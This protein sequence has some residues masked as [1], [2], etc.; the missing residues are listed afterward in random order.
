VAFRYAPPGNVD[1][2]A[3]RPARD[4]FLD[5]WH[6]GMLENFQREI[7]GLPSTNRLFFSE[8]TSAATSGDLPITWNAFPLSIA[9]NIPDDR[10][11]RW[12]AAD[13]P[14]SVDRSTTA[15]AVPMPCR[16]QDEYCE[17]FVYRPAPGG[18]ISR[19]VFTA[20][21]PE[22]WIALAKHDFERVLQLYRE[23]VSP[24]VQPDELKLKQDIAFS[25][26]VVLKKGTY[27]PYNRWNST[28]GVMHLTH[29]ANTLGAEI[30]LAARATIPRRDVSGNRVTDVRRFA[31]GSNFGDPNRSSDPNIGHGVNFTALPGAGGVAQSITLADPVALYID[32]IAS[33]SITDENGNPLSGWFKIVRGVTGRGLMAVLEP[34][35]GATFGLDKIRVGNR[36]LTHGGQV[37]ER[38][39]MV[40]YGK[41]ASLG[42]PAPPLQSCINHCCR[43]DSNADISRINLDHVPAGD[44]CASSTPKDAF[45]E[46]TGGAQPVAGIA[47]RAAAEPGATITRLGL[48]RLAGGSHVK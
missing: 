8:S 29:P 23:H 9:R 48:T 39:Q 11:A 28:D 32:R 3:G 26:D 20:E 13:R 25:E 36:K 6:A 19:I 14:G 7:T 43:P 18:P 22:Y 47:A 12:N 46:L 31:C 38:I 1:D 45:P 33:G 42:Q 30:N 40:L 41:T 24:N 21:A 15:Q 35:E 44:A 34:P 10:I 5:D 4:G 27:N 17:W 37:A 16:L 2:L